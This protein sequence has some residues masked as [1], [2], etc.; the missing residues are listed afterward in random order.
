MARSV[1]GP[2]HELIIIYDPAE[3][4][5]H[6]ARKRSSEPSVTLEEKCPTCGRPIVDDEPDE[7][8]DESHG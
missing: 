6:P 3:L 1:L 8:G 7:E 4:R 5:G 2:Q